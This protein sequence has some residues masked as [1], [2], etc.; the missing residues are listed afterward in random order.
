MTRIDFARTGYQPIVLDPAPA[1]APEQGE[2]DETSTETVA[3][4]DLVESTELS[5]P[6]EPALLAG[7]AW[8]EPADGIAGSLMTGLVGALALVL[9]VM[10]PVTGV[11]IGSLVVVIVTIAI[12]IRLMRRG[13]KAQ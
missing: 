4:F 10:A 2:S 12:V 13:G 6:A 9:A 7:S 3:E 1:Q 8:V 5:E 11:K